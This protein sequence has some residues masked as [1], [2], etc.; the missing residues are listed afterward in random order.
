MLSIS[1]NSIVSSG[2]T[3]AVL[4][5]TIAI[6]GNAIAITEFQGL[7]DKAN[8]QFLFIFGKQESSKEFLKSLICPKV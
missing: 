8:Y 2:N 4:E 5:N 3:L 1:W 7:V 6:F